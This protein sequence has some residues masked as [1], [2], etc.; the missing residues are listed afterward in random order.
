[1]TY[2]PLSHSHRK[3]YLTA[4]PHGV[5]AVYIFQV[6]ETALICDRPA[7]RRHP[8]HAFMPLCCAKPGIARISAILPTGS[9][10]A[11]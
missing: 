10:C 8:Q 1:M 11:T 7:Q 9:S 4:V 3:A 5:L 2:L 6:T